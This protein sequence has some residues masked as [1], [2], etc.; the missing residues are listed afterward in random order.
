MKPSI[1]LVR[2]NAA[3]AQHLA[4][5]QQGAAVFPDG[6]RQAVFDDLRDAVDGLRLAV[7]ILP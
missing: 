1:C 2:S 5:R 3:Q 6:Q 4:K 7:V